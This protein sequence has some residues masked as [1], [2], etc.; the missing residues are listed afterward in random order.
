MHQCWKKLKDSTKELKKIRSLCI[1]AMLTAICVALGMFHLQLGSSLQ[2]SF[3]FLAMGLIGAWFGPVP[4]ALC[5]GLSDLISFFLFPTG[6]FFPGFTLSAIVGGFLYGIVMYQRQIRFWRVLVA[7]SL[8][9]LIVNVLLNTLWVVILYGYGV[10]ALLPVRVAKNLVTIPLNAI[11]FYF[12][13]K[14]LSHYY[15]FK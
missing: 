10:W 12:I 7:F 8:V 9:G 15:R 6:S 2:L 11:I 13:S 3:G 4:A 5:G 14:P 1:C